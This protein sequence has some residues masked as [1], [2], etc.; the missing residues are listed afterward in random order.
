VSADLG[1]RIDK[2]SA[3]KRALL[4]RH[5]LEQQRKKAGE[6]AVPRRDR[7]KP[8]PLSFS[9]QR[10]W[11]LDQWAP[12]APTYN[13]AVPWRV[14]GDLDVDALRAALEEVVRRHEAVRTVFDVRDGEPVQVVLD[15]WSFDL[16]VSDLRH[17][18][19]PDRQHEAERLLRAQAR[20]PFD[21][22][23]DLMLRATLLRLSEA[24]HI[25]SFEEHHV[26][27]DGWS[28]GILFRELAELYAA[29]RTGRQPDLPELTVQYGD[30]AVWQ[31]QRLQGAL[32]DEHLSHWRQ[33]LAGT[34]GSLRMPTD[35]PRPEVQ[36]FEGAHYHFDLPSGLAESVRSLSRSEGVTP[37]M[38]LLAAFATLLYRTTGRDDV[39]IGSPIANRGR[40]E[41][42]NLIGFFSNTLVLR[43]RLGGNPTFR[44]LLQRVRGVALSA[45]AHQ[46]LP[47][48]QVVEAVRPARDAAVNPLF[49]VNFRVQSGPPTA[50]SLPGLELE[51]IQLDVGFSRFD[52]ALELQLREDSLRGYFEY[53]TSLFRPETGIRL[54]GDFGQ[55][56]EHVLER[57]DDRLLALELR[58]AAAG[59]DGRDPAPAAI[60]S[61]RERSGATRPR[62]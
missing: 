10:L 15:D 24:E 26:A 56:L 53:N 40:V 1:N 27:F 45:Y 44:E 57:P 49:Q 43:V 50:L 47:F 28:D 42:E 2:L 22:R 46:D 55:L 21:L 35:H 13:A 34:P 25:L 59:A 31:R 20:R 14:R 33:Q 19:E 4:E 32:L 29:H 36:S 38:T 23:R 62:P 12:G 3:E 8:C 17:L 11:F 30:F 61:F 5:L 16:S 39:L 58:G 6:E 18:R 37:F 48:E 52:L 54:V 41:L 51:P 60:R 9:Q 7:T